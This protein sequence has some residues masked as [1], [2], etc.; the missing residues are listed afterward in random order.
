M[1]ERR[2]ITVGRRLG[3]SEP[4]ARR[5]WRKRDYAGHRPGRHQGGACPQGKALDNQPDGRGARLRTERHRLQHD[6]GPTAGSDVVVIHRRP[7]PLL[8]GMSPRNDPRDDEREDRQGRSPRRSST[9]APM[10]S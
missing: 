1:S 5:F 9:R 8:P 3:M 7:P 2:K 10:Q 4:R 6:Y